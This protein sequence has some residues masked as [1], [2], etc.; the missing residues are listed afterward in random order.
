M[1]GPL[2]YLDVFLIAISLISGLLAMYR[3]LT[4]EI[5]SILSWVAAAVAAAL[6]VI[7]QKRVA[8]DIA[9]QIGAPVQVAQIGLGALIFLVVLIVVHLITSRISDSILDSRVGMIDRLLGFVFGVVRGFVLV[10][11]PFML[12]E[13]AFPNQEQ[14]LAF[15][16]QSMS[17]P[18]IRSTGEMLRSTLVR[19]IPRSFTEPKDEQRQGRLDTPRRV[20]AAATMERS[21]RL[22]ILPP[23]HI[24]V[25]RAPADVRDRSM[26]DSAI[27]G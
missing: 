10:V 26:P 23:L 18:Y 5:L 17:L 27:V 16:R 7:S 20:V 6:F 15:V 9:Q 1:V 25:T 4:R 11:I 13:V 19:L 8:E 21:G 22:L 2:S 14:Q 3:G 12:Y 24:S